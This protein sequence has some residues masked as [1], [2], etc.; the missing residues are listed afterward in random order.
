MGSLEIHPSIPV[1]RP[2][3]VGLGRRRPLDGSPALDRNFVPLF[4][5]EPSIGEAAR[6]RK[7]DCALARSGHG[8]ELPVPGAMRMKAV[9][10]KLV[11]RVSWRRGSCITPAKTSK[12]RGQTE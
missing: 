12:P 1:V 4:A 7:L 10:R 5:D 6:R 9:L 3:G 11:P 2:E 8:A